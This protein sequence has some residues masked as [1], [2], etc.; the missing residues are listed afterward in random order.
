[1]SDYSSTT[2]VVAITRLYLGGE[3]T[4][5]TTTLPTATEVSK[6]LNRASGV[7]NVALANSGFA[8]PVTETDAKLA[9]DEWVTL[10]AAQFVE[11]SQPTT[12]WGEVENP[13]ADMLNG[14]QRDAAKFVAMMAIGF[15]NLGVPTTDPAGQGIRYTGQL[16]HSLRDDPQDTSL[17]QPHFRRNQFDA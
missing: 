14:M 17:A 15:K 3:T 7:L 10:H 13:R 5:N 4:Y 1:M 9:C 12:E 16:K 11:L 2:E 6:F 8:V